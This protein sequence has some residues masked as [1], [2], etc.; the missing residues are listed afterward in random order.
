MLIGSHLLNY[1]QIVDTFYIPDVWHLSTLII[2]NRVRDCF[3]ALLI[4]CELRFI[5]KHICKASSINQC[6]AI[7]QSLINMIYLQTDNR[8]TIYLETILAIFYILNLYRLRCTVTE[9]TLGF[10]MFV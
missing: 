2:R 4:W 8:M 7:N 9:L 3:Y 1:N 5:E 10:V 6:N